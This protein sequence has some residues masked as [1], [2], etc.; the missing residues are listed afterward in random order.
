MKHVEITPR[1]KR[2]LAKARDHYGTW[3]ALAAAARIHFSLPG[4]YA[5]GKTAEIEARTWKKLLPVLSPF[6]E[7][8]PLPSSLSGGPG[9]EAVPIPMPRTRP[10]PIYGLAQAAGVTDFHGDVIPDGEYHLPTI[11]MPADGRRYAAFRVEGESMMPRIRDGDVVVCD[12]DD[13]V[14]NGHLV[15]AKARGTVYIKRWRRV[16]HAV[17]LESLNTDCPSLE[18]AESEVEWRLRVRKIVSEA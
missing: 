18:V 2:A 12:V 3:T 17:L 15:A 11:D 13:E 14:G 4:K 9:S 7:P 6:L 10:V 1:V 8:E 5:A 16:G